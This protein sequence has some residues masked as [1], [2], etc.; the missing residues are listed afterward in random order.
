MGRASP[1]ACRR[2]PASHTRPKYVAGWI[3]AAFGGRRAGTSAPLTAVKM[4]EN[5]FTRLPCI[6]APPLTPPAPPGLLLSSFC[7]EGGSQ[8]ACAAARDGLGPAAAQS[9][10][11]Y[12]GQSLHL[13]RVHPVFP[14]FPADRLLAGRAGA[15]YPADRAGRLYRAG[16]CLVQGFLAGAASGS[17]LCARSAGGRD[18]WHAQ[19]P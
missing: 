17:F 12:A 1:P 6:P 14:D 19:R 4:L 9:L 7:H 3:F 16:Q 2:Q 5:S 13:V 11:D 15:V 18:L 8:V 10:R